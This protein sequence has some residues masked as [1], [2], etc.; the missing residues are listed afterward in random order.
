MERDLGSLETGKLADF[1]LLDRASLIPKATW[2]SGRE[3]W[4]AAA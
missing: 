2:I 3:V 4:S 1:T